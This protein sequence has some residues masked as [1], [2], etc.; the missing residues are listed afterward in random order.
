MIVE[1][2]R[3]DRFSVNKI[4]PRESSPA[5]AALDGYTLAKM[6]RAGAGKC[7]I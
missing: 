6:G 1:N 5:P 2:I 7:G 4:V 3:F